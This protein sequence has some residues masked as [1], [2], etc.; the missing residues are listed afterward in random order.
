MKPKQDGDNKVDE[1]GQKILIFLWYFGI[2]TSVVKMLKP[3]KKE[4]EMMKRSLLVVAIAM[5]SIAAVLPVWTEEAKKEE[6][7]VE[8]ERG[9]QSEKDILVTKINTL[10]NQEMRVTVLQQLLNEATAQLRQM[11][12]VFCDQYNLDLDK[13][14]AG[15]YQYDANAGKL[16]EKKG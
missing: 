11:E 4:G 13:Y 14:R 6:K 12:A 8:I 9:V 5:V 2:I 3:N 15:K 7:R 10:R 16:I 1:N